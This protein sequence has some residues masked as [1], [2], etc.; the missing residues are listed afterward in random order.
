MGHEE[1]LFKVREMKER[2]KG[3]IDL[4]GSKIFRDN[5]YIFAQKEGMGG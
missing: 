4:R 2:G 1:I 5:F 3:I